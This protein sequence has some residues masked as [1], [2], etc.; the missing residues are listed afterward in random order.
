MGNEFTVYGGVRFRKNDID[1]CSSKENN[2]RTEYTV[3]L[4]TGQILIFCDQH[5]PR[6]KLT[7]SV[8]AHNE[9]GRPWFT[10]NDL[11]GVTL[12]GN[13][14]KRD[15]IEFKGE[16]SLNSVYVNNDK[17]SDDVYV[18]KNYHYNSKTG[19]MLDIN[20]GNFLHLGK[21]DKEI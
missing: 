11:K 10:G 7:P 4:K 1:A 17:L 8:S 14:S 20:E 2:G 5:D 21:E 18:H 13:P 6:G 9:H 19:Q 12:I 16:S 15:Y 3:K